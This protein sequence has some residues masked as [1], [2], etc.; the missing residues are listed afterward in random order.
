MNSRT[1]VFLY[2]TLVLFGLGGCSFAN[3]SELQAT[4][5]RLE[6]Q[7]KQI[8]NLNAQLGL[9]ASSSG[10]P[11]QAEIWAQFQALR[12]DFN[13]LRGQLDDMTY[14]E[15]G[16]GQR[17]RSIREQLTRLE[18]AIRQIASELAIDLPMLD[19]PLAPGAGSSAGSSSVPASAVRSAPKTGGAAVA[20]KTPPKGAAASGAKGKTDPKN[21]DLA[22]TLYDS[23]AKAFSDRKYSNAINIFADFINTYPKH[24]LI[25]NSH[26]W[27]G[28]S[29]YQLKNYSNA[30]L[31][32]QQVIEKYPGSNKLQS[33]MLK[34]GISMHRRGQKEAAK[35][36][37]NELIRKYPKGTEAAR[38]KQ[39]LESNP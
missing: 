37:L 30:I 22:K 35:V 38:A 16:E 33:A 32:Y 34:Q 25:S 5:K 6:A 39:F 9:E 3:R 28:E 7:E 15:G 12:Q 23:G 8:H 17:P 10:V 31:A 36:R 13:I 1:F 21:A 18:A 14:Q 19:T 26:F 4:N 20:G 24:S 27:Q 29:Y 2:G 11:M